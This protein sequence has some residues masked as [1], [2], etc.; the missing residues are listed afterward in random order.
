MEPSHTAPQTPTSSAK[1]A[2]VKL[3]CVVPVRHS[4]RHS[5]VATVGAVLVV[6]RD[7]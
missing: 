3:V 1:A 2:E 7:L 4:V 5:F 6:C